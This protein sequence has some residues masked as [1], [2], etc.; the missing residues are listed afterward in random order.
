ML[1]EGQTGSVFVG[2]SMP[3]VTGQIAEKKDGKTIHTPK[4]SAIDVGIKLRVTPKIGASGQLQLRIEAE[5]TEVGP[6]V[7]LSSAPADGKATDNRT[8]IAPSF[9][10]HTFQT[11]VI[12]PDGGTVVLRSASPAHEVLWVL[13]P[14]IVRTEK[15]ATAP[16]APAPKPIPVAPARP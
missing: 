12:V 10:T 5:N 6:G 13:T 4:V 3:M 15:K 2:Q 16:D 7:Q 11:T 8:T 9:N 14:H 1:L